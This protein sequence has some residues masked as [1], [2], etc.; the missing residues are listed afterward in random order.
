VGVEGLQVERQVRT[1]GG[2]LL[3]PSAKQVYLIV[4]YSAE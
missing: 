3:T 2:G 1:I 4:Q